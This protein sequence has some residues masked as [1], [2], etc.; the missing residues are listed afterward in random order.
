MF[1]DLLETW[2]AHSAINLGFLHN[3]P[4][5]GLEAVGA[6][7]GMSV[8]QQLGHCHM[9]RV[10]WIEGS[11]KK[12]VKGT[13]QFARDAHLTHEQLVEALSFSAQAITELLKLRHSANKGVTGFPGSLTSF[14]GYLI[15]HESHHQG[16]MV[17]AL[18]QS[19]LPMERENAYA[20]WKGWWARQVAE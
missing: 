18:K 1:E 12:L 17:L 3:L 16:Q 20:L 2:Q 6:S 14:V 15:A 4:G 9:V 10:R 19:G 8:G 11:S 7:G 13:V 5:G